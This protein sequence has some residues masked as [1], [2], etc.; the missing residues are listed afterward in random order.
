[1]NHLN[2]EESKRNTSLDAVPNMKDFYI[3][4]GFN[5]VWDVVI[6]G[7]RPKP[8]NI[9]SFELEGVTV[10]KV[11]KENLYLFLGYE[12]QIQKVCDRTK[13]FEMYLENEENLLCIAVKEIEGVY[14][15]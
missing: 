3:R 15:Y 1:M 4:K 13:Y 11:T 9:L 8:E 6:Y 14:F 2:I 7:G 12:K 10:K 5:Y